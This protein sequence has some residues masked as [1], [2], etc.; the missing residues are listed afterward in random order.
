M[1][2]ILKNPDNEDNIKKL[3][4]PC[5]K[6]GTSKSLGEKIFEK[7]TI[8]EAKFRRQYCA[9]EYSLRKVML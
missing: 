7:K 4:D 3:C 6:E 8:L 5:F 2:L 1:L 9:N